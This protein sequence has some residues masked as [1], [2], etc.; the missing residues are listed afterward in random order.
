MPRHN[1]AGQCQRLNVPHLHRRLLLPQHRQHCLYHV[2]SWPCLRRRHQDAVRHGS[3]LT[4][5]RQHLHHLSQG[6]VLC[7]RP[8]HRLSRN[9]VTAPD[10]QDCVRRVRRWLSPAQ[11]IAGQL[12]HLSGRKRMRRR[13]RYPMCC[14]QVHVCSRNERLCV[15]HCWRVQQRCWKLHVLAVP[16]SQVLHIGNYSF[17]RRWNSYCQHRRER[18]RHLP[19][20]QLLCRVVGNGRRVRRRSVPACDW[21]DS[22]SLVR[23]QQL[24][25]RRSDQHLC[26]RIV[27]RH[28]GTVRLYHLPAAP[29]V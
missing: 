9:H 25:Q 4:G 8:P 16:R 28:Q 14:A 29:Q 1:V 11:H 24:M 2:R 26:Q 23:N 13:C 12:Y 19:A 27:H 7:R 3:L 15:L 17:V 5:G 20:V 18:V 6:I 22:V 10:W 21:Q